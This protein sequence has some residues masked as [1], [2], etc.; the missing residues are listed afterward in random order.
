MSE[1][2][3]RRQSPIDFVPQRVVSLVPSMTESLFDLDLGNRLIGITDYCVRPVNR[4]H[5]ILK[6][7]GTQNPHIET[8]IRLRPDLVLLN[9]E[10]N[11]AVDV[12]AL[13]SA[14]V[15]IWVTGPR[16]VFDALNTL[17]DIMAIFDHAVMVPRVRE[18][19]RA[20]DYTQAA[21]QLGSP[22]RVFAPIARDPWTTFN[23]DTYAH[24]ILR[25]CGGENV[26][27][28]HEQRYP[29]CS[30]DDVL[31]AQPEIILLP[32]E[33]FSEEEIAPFQSLDIPA[34]HNGQIHRIDSSLL[35]WH[36]T[37]MAYALRDLP[38]LLVREK[39][40]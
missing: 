9:D 12:D 33:L 10:E 40:D 15:S 26:F 23:R 24:D 1:H 17:W 13:R 8:I 6:V 25:V 2:G 35:T 4:V 39:N 5:S 28:P 20:Y 38:P 3:L 36:G 30:L 27:G 19:E 7:G 29:H 14:G 32:D 34:V 11:R 16:T 18:I 31:E 22:R 37:R 21:A